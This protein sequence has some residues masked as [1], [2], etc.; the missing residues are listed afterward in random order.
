MAISGKFEEPKPIVVITPGDL[1]QLADQ[2]N[3]QIALLQRNI[4]QLK[5]KAKEE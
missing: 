1:K 5:N 4:L 3:L 2:M